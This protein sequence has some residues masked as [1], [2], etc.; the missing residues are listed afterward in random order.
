[1]M[2]LIA[3][4]PFSYHSTSRSRIM[5]RL[6]LISLPP[7]ILLG[8]SGIIKAD[9]LLLLANCIVVF[10]LTFSFMGVEQMSLHLANDSRLFE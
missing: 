4:L 3:D 9:G 10:L 8:E 7:V 2:L 1:M 6:F 5:L